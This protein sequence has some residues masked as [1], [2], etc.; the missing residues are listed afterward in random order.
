MAYFTA[1][2]PYVLLTILLVRGVTLPGAVDGIVFYLKPDFDKLLKPQGWLDA[3]TQ[4]FFSYAI[5]LGAMIALG[6]YNKFNNNCYRCI[7]EERLSGGHSPLC[8]LHG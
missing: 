3:G 8:E 6:S 1:T 2:F 4:I 5:G 7:F